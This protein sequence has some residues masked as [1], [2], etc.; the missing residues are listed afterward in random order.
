MFLGY[1]A[2]RDVINDVSIGYKRELLSSQ[3]GRTPHPA[4]GLQNF[5]R[6]TTRAIICR[7]ITSGDEIP[8]VN[9]GVLQNFTNTIC[10]EDRVLF[11]EF[12]HCQTMVLSVH[13]NTLSTVTVNARQIPPFK[14]AAR[15]AA[16]N[17]NLGTV[18]TFIGATWALPKTNASCYNLPGGAGCL[19]P[20]KTYC[21]EYVL[22]AITK[23]V[24]FKMLE[25]S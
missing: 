3:E 10:N 17:S 22:R 1:N 2:E 13:I 9:A 19:S 11:V 14:R 5:S 4:T 23:H 24:E 18:I 25:W 21:T 15:R 20:K 16:C 12:M 6:H 7:I 8:L